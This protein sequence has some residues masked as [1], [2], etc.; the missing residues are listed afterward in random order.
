[1]GVE[2]DTEPVGCQRHRASGSGVN[3]RALDLAASGRGFTCPLLKPVASEVR[4]L[5]GTEGGSGPGRLT[6][7]LSDGPSEPS[8]QHCR[9]HQSLPSLLV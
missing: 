5:E 2:E 6:I 4:E 7:S 3:F 1:M 8:K 9:Q